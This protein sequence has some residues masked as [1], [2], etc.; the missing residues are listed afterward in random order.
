MPSIYDVANH[1][2]D[3]AVTDGYSGAALFNAQFSSFMEASPDGSTSQRRTLSMAPGLSIPS[4]GVISALNERWIV[5]TGNVDGIYGQ[6]IRQ[7]FWMK[8]TTGLYGVML[9]GVAALGGAG[10][11]AYGHKIYLKDTVNGVSDSEYDPFYNFYFHPSEA[12]AK[13]SI[14]KSGSTYYYVRSTNLGISGLVEAGSDELDT[15]AY[16]TVTFSSTGAYDPVTDAYAA[17]ATVTSGLL[18]DRYML[19]QQKTEADLKS[20]SGDMSLLVSTS[21]ITPVVGKLVI[22]SSR[23]WKIL[24]VTAEQ[25][26]WLLHIRRV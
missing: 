24:A 4:R 20:M 14:L 22:L 6:A 15:G 2:D 21:V 13:G 16:Q 17:G 5:G 25:D 11:S 1:Y 26:A 23:S 9:P 19:Y 10:T 12:T 18:M 7:S 3:I 8:K